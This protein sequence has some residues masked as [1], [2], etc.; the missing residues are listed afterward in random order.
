MLGGKPTSQRKKLRFRVAP[1]LGSPGH[2]FWSLPDAGRKAHFMEE[3]TEVQRLL[4]HW[5]S[6]A[7]WARTS[8]CAHLP[9]ITPGVC[10]FKLDIPFPE[11]NCVS[12][13]NSI[14]EKL[15]TQADRFS[16]E[17]VNWDFGGSQRILCSG[18]HLAWCRLTLC[19]FP[20]QADV[21]S[22]PPRCVRQPGLQKPVLR[23]HSR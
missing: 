11:C 10:M 14:K 21:C 20:G 6:L 23:H 19:S 16:E 7:S 1:M 5:S 18:C 13:L 12:P 3:E 22:V 17:E 2:F 9:L 15:M 8:P 4:G